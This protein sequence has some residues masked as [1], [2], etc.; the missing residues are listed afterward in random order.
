MNDIIVSFLAW[1]NGAI[2]LL[3]FFIQ[4]V[5]FCLPLLFVFSVI[6]FIIILLKVFLSKYFDFD[7]SNIEDEGETD[8]NL[9]NNENEKFKIKN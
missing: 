2:A 6:C 8:L 4:M 1:W 7:D 9:D 5:A 3:K